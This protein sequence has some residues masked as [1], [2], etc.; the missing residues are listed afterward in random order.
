MRNKYHISDT[1]NFN[2]L[3]IT[4]SKIAFSYPTIFLH[5]LYYTNNNK[6]ESPAC[7]ILLKWKLNNTFCLPWLALI[8][9]VIE[10]EFEIPLALL[11]AMTVVLESSNKP[12]YFLYQRILTL[13]TSE[14]FPR[15]LK[16]AIC[17]YL[18]I[19]YKEENIYR[20]VPYFTKIHKKAR[21]IDC[22]SNL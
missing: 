21:N 20:F 17:R 10:S 6:I 2:P 11:L 3:I 12:Y 14:V 1:N 4:E 15:R 7:K 22:Y 13:Y 9:P 8:I 19:I 16:L 18:G 5:V